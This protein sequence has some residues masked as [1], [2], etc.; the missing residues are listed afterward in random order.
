MSAELDKSKGTVAFWSNKIDAWHR[1]GV[2]TDGY[3]SSEEIIQYAG[4]DFD[5]VKEPV[6]LAN[7][8]IIA[9]SFATVRKDNNT[10]LGVVGSKYVVTQNKEAFNFFD[11]VI[12]TE[13]ITYQ[14]AGALKEGRIIYVTAKL[15]EGL[16]INGNDPHDLYINF[17]NIHDGTGSIKIYPTMIRTVCNNTLSASLSDN[18]K[19]K[20]GLLSVRHT[21]NQNVKLAQAKDVL[22]ISKEI[23]EEKKEFLESIAKINISTDLTKELALQLICDYAELDR[24]E[25]SEPILNVLSTRKINIYNNIMDSINNGVG[26]KDL[27]DTG[28]KFFNGVTYFTSNVKGKQEDRMYDTFFGSSLDMQNKALQLVDNLR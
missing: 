24:L 7:G 16:K 5:V 12:G 19:N 26:Q 25:K 9:G 17:Y 4:L 27:A 10:A 18:R 1:S 20:R 23:F 6:Y 11:Q 13:D 2:V 28:Y 22:K 21:A 8:N 3:K 15:N 14:T